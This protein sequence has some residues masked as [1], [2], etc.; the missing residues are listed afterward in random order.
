MNDNNQH[1]PAND[2]S[3]HL[4]EPKLARSMGG[5][6]SFAISMSTICIL[7][8]GITSFHV[9]FCGVG[10]AAIGIGWPLE[11][12]FA[13]IVALTMAQVASAF[14]T[15]GGTYHWAYTLG[16]KGWG[17]VTAWFSIA[18]L[19]T[20]LA[21][22]DV[23]LCGFVESVARE[24]L[25]TEKASDWVRNGAIVLV[26]FSQAFINHHGMRLTRRLNDFAGYLIVVV[27]MLLTLAM[28]FKI[29]Q[30]DFDPARLFTF[31]NYSGHGPPGEIP[32][33]PRTENMFLLFALGLLLP[34]YTL[35]GF[36]ASAQTAEET[37]NPTHA[38]PRGIVRAVLISGIAG[39]IV[40]SAVVLAAPDLDRAAQQGPGCF[41][42]IVGD[43]VPNWKVRLPLY[44][45]IAVAQYL[46]GLAVVTSVS[47]MTFAF[48]RDGGIPLSR[49]LRRISPVR[50]TPSLAIW[51]V[52]AAAAFFA[53]IDYETIAAVCAI[54]VYLSYVLPTTL[55]LLA[56]GR[57]WTRMGPWHLGHWYR[58]LAVLCV[59]GC[60]GLI[61]IGLQPPNEIA[62]WVVGGSI[63]VL[64]AIWFG[65]KCRHFPGPPEEI[66]LQL[67]SG[68]HSTQ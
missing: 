16:G 31:T 25:G 65:Y 45:G 29:M 43:V 61:V 8:G 55:G 10:P 20:A 23:G 48:A 49:F 2:R 27:A 5:F 14:P 35:T 53:V 52:A 60:A 21:A 41:N 62:V 11:V 39:W 32:T 9:G 19:V 15:A 17:W 46:C 51:A 47:R 56:H 7:S 26:I 50:R 28:V 64:A 57:T 42:C 63:L 24:F 1:L 3:P 18:G 36:D 67:R 33:Y 13:L 66:L 68:N 40:L 6:S 58:P 30:S 44:A 34:A 37:R 59:L 22:V 4:A 54:Y 12:L 38:V